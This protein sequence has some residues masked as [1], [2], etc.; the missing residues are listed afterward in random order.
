MNEQQLAAKQMQEEFAYIINGEKSLGIETKRD[1]ITHLYHHGGTVSEYYRG[2]Q[3]EATM[4]KD[5]KYLELKAK[6]FGDTT[7]SLF[8][9]SSF[10][11]ELDNNEEI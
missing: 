8:F 1:K 7:M 9:P 2:G 5:K 11:K 10:K 6:Y 4:P 3:V